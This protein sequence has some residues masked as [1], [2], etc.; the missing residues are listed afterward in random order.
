MSP[1]SWAL[2]SLLKVHLQFLNS[3]FLIFFLLVNLLG[4]TD[5]AIG[6][7]CFP[8]RWCF[9]VFFTDKV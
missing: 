3:H 2:H 1:F 5:G 8:V 6:L 4:L 7:I 9:P